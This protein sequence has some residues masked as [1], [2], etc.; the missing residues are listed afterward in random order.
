MK[1]WLLGGIVCA[2]LS[3][4]GAAFACGSDI[5]ARPIRPVVLQSN[6]SFQVS[7]L[8]D[9]AA[10]L[11]SM[12]TSHDVEARALEQEANT[13]SN[14]ARVLRNQASLVDFSDRGSIMAIA[15]ELASRA[16]VVRSRANQERTQGAELRMEAQ[17]LRQRALVLSRGNGGGGWH[18]RPLP[19]PSETTTSL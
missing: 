16:M 4:S 13:L 6:V 18:K 14:R 12:A 8:N 2:C 11:E 7:E 1:A 3:A 19:L 10:R 17:A 9:R 15:D 5:E